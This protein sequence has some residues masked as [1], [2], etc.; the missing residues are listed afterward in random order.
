MRPSKPPQ[1]KD[2]TKLKVEVENQTNAA[3]YLSIM[4]IDARG[5]ITLLFPTAWK[6]PD[7]AARIAE[8]GQRGKITVPE[9]ERDN[10]NFVVEGTSGLPELLILVSTKPLRQALQGMQNVARSR[11]I[12]RGPIA[13]ERGGF[14]E[15]EALGIMG[16]ILGD[17]DDLS[18]SRAGDATVAVV[19]TNRSN[20]TSLYDNST[21]AVLS[22]VF[23][24]VS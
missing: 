3:L 4:L 17:V 16:D 14:T 15:D 11:G 1:F 10:Y 2:G 24:I 20:D 5:M 19:S 8:V 9:P 13:N 21:L 12:E 22:A 6:S 23:E 7:E 18:R